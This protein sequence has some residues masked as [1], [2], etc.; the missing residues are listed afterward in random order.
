[1]RVALLGGVAVAGATPGRLL[2]GAQLG[3]RR[4]HLLVAAL[5]LEPGPQSTDRLAELIWEEPP[6]TAPVAVRGLVAELRR[7]LRTAFD[8]DLV[9]TTP[10]GYRLA[11]QVSTDVVELEEA[12]SSAAGFSAAGRWRAVLGKLSAALSVDPLQLAA[13][14][15]ALWLGPHRDRLKETVLEAGLLAVAAQRNLED[16]AAAVTLARRLVANYRIDE[17]THRALIETLDRAGDRSGAVQAF[18]ACR[19]VLASELGIDPSPQTLATYLRIIRGQGITGHARIPTSTTTF[20]GREAQLQRLAT[21]IS[22]PGLVTVTG[23]GGVGKSRLAEEVA[24]RAIDLPGGRHWVS[25]FPVREDELVDAT[26]LMALGLP[27]TDDAS[28]ALV[29]HF[30]RLGRTL[31][32]LDGVEGV[33]D[34]AATLVS[35]LLAEAPDASILVT[36]RTPLG[37]PDENRLQLPPVGLPENLPVG[38]M[39]ASDSVR[40]LMDRLAELG[41]A[42]EIDESLAPAVTALCHRCGGLPLALE[43]VAAQLTMMSPDDLVS[44]LDDVNSE[45]AD[46]LRRVAEASHSLLQADE[47]AVFRRLSVL[48]GRVDLTAIQSVACDEDIPRVRVVRILRELSAEGLLEAER[49]GSR[50]TYVQ[51]DDLHRFAQGKLADAGE[52]ALSYQRLAD[53]V[54]SLLPD[55]PRSPPAPFADVVTSL[56]P[57]LRGLLG[58]GVSGLA[59]PTRCLEIAFRLH[60]YWAATNVGEGCFWLTRL[61]DSGADQ[62]QPWIGYA[63]YALGYL[64]YWAG[65]DLQAVPQ[66]EAAID[67]LASVD[68]AYVA[69]TDVLGRHPRRSRSWPG[70]G[71][72][73]RARD[74]RRCRAWRRPARVDDDGRRKRAGRTG[75]PQRGHLRQRSDC[76]VRNRWFC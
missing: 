59:D 58:A 33:R 26:V 56:L 35:V 5:A 48:E 54:R 11:S 29:G 57:S 38:E 63:T 74:H 36:S 21:D 20:V 45:T 27:V 34:G 15:H 50:W 73:G 40:I 71:S 3:G 22:H 19:K 13:G 72:A 24:R 39:P 18:E 37:I 42:L 30:A 65:R 69:R 60:R 9:V 62:E 6:A 10:A 46:T 49:S 16:H 66:L 75:R 64:N 44:H 31:L 4:I 12:V 55:D 43:L 2:E 47:S 28:A 51:D 17:R 25:F 76:V 14:L 68:T 8:E 67:L 61:L 32:V 41:G 70:G 52:V 7:N 53:F 23:A 1:M